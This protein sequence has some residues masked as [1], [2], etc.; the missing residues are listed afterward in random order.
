MYVHILKFHMR[1][2][3]ICPC[4]AVQRKNVH[5]KLLKTLIEE[6][7]RCYIE[8]STSKCIKNPSRISLRFTSIL[9]LRLECST[10][11]NN[12]ALRKIPEF[13]TV[14]A[15]QVSARSIPFSYG[16]KL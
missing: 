11:H 5:K 12:N 6:N 9:K 4:L 8:P 2:E 10:R 13:Q 15:R 3:N 16:F 14:K 1:G 7:L